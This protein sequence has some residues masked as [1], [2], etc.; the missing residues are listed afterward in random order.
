MDMKLHA[1]EYMDF[2]CGS[3]TMPEGERRFCCGKCPSMGKPLTIKAV[4]ASNPTLMSFLSE[5]EQREAITLA[6]A[7]GPDRIDIRS[8]VPDPAPNSVPDP[9]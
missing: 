9:Q 6:I 5:D 7:A 1:D 3:P 4:F 8:S 2:P